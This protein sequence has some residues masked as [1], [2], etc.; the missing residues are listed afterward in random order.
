MILC[1]CDI[2]NVYWLSKC[3]TSLGF[4]KVLHNKLFLIVRLRIKYFQLNF[5]WVSSALRGKTGEH[6]IRKSLT[7]LKFDSIHETQ[8]ICSLLPQIKQ[9]QKKRKTLPSSDYCQAKACAVLSEVCTESLKST[10]LIQM[11]KCDLY[12]CKKEKNHWPVKISIFNVII[13][14][15]M[16]SMEKDSS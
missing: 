9:R 2:A 3:Q 16:Q 7:T 5:G 6:L 12:Y 8:Y 4:T 13:I 14:W 11:V 15:N 10:H 1:K